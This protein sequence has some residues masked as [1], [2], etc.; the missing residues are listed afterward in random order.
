[1]STFLCNS[2][3][4]QFRFIILFMGL[5]TY[6]RAQTWQQKA[7]AD[8]PRTSAVSFMLNG[9]VYMAGG[10]SVASGAIYTDMWEYDPA[11]DT[12]QQKAALPGTNPGCTHG[13]AFS[14]NGKGYVGL[15]IGTDG[16]YKKELYE[17]DP[18]SD[19][20]NQMADLPAV[21]REGSACFVINNKAY[22]VGGAD[23]SRK[24][25]FW[26]YDPATN[27][28]ASKGT[29]P[30]GPI[31]YAAGFSINGKGYMMGGYPDNSQ[32]NV[33]NK[34]FEYDPVT[35]T[36]A[37]KTSF[38]G[39][40]RQSHVAFVINNRGYCGLGTS[41]FYSTRYNDF[42]SYDPVT[43]TW[44][45]EA[46]FPGEQR[47]FAIAAS[48]NTNAFVGTGY[49]S[50]ENQDFYEFVAPLFSSLGADKK[51]QGSATVYPNP[52]TGTLYISGL[53]AG[54]ASYAIY[55]SCGERI[56]SDIMP[57]GGRLETANLKPGA[58]FLHINTAGKIFKQTVII[59]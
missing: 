19:S 30:L 36:W 52:S 27:A 38:P 34:M 12:W 2:K 43:G 40:A 39:T 47:G 33:T 18:A 24:S 15:G 16:N 7:N 57:P 21:A 9:K 59:D 29:S 4:I 50:S 1:M 42:F 35:N 22:I 23:I 54:T 11:A 49:G 48:D 37:Q 45:P 3:T 5:L 26:E 6:V 51:M 58:Y 8:K 20:W 46:V 17:Y 53:D 31:I 41:K 56:V 10:G 55:N 13:V 32:D 44:Q 28:W 25:D 14:I